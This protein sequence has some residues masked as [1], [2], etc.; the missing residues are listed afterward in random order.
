MRRLIVLSFPIQ[1]VF[2]GSLHKYIADNPYH[3]QSSKEAHCCSGTIPINIVI[4][5]PTPTPTPAPLNKDR[6]TAQTE[7]QG[8]RETE[9]QKDRDTET[10]RK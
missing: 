10:D 9:R 8:D 1:L 5:A 7:R 6:L 4:V 2:P 3:L